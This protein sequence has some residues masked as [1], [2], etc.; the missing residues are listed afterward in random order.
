[1][2]PCLPTVPSAPP[3]NIHLDMVNTTALN[4]SWHYVTL[5]HQNGIIL[6]YRVRFQQE[7]GGPLLWNMTVG[8]DVHHFLFSDLLIFQSYSIQMKAFTIKGDGPWN[9]KTYQLTDESS[10]WNGRSEEINM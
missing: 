2:F 7:D 1:M 4:A 3:Y 8:P 10:K 5:I 9:N 6:G